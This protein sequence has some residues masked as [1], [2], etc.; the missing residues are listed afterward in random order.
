MLLWSGY[1]ITSSTRVLPVL[2]VLIA[3]AAVVV[4][5]AGSPFST[6]AEGDVRVQRPPAL[7]VF[8]VGAVNYGISMLIMFAFAWLHPVA[9]EYHPILLGLLLALLS[10]TD[11]H[12]L[13]LGGGAA[14]D[15]GLG[16]SLA[17]SGPGAAKRSNPARPCAWWPQ[18]WRPHSLTRPA[19]ESDG[20]FGFVRLHTAG[21]R[22]GGSL[23]NGEGPGPGRFRTSRRVRRA[24]SLRLAACCWSAAYPGPDWATGRV[25]CRPERTCRALSVLFQIVYPA[26]IAI[27]A[28]PVVFL[29]TLYWIVLAPGGARQRSKRAWNTW[30]GAGLCGALPGAAGH[31]HGHFLWDRLR[32]VGLLGATK[33]A[34]AALG[35]F[36]RSHHGSATGR[37][38]SASS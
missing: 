21:C 10:N 29:M 5:V 7:R 16:R 28:L 17:E 30:R 24:C 38:S 37:S 12:S 19:D 11:I 22:A 26:A 3:G 2:S 35:R 27:K 18:A 31:P 23:V 4:F 25:R 9:A 32:Y 15:V 6:L 13:L 14:G 20:R 8:G 1:H 36:L 33:K 34:A